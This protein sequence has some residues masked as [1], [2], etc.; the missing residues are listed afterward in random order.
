MEMYDCNVKYWG[1]GVK[2]SL[3]YI[4]TVRPACAACVTLSK[5]QKRKSG[6]DQAKETL[7]RPETLKHLFSRN[8]K[9]LLNQV[10]LRTPGARDWV[11][12][13]DY[14][15]ASL[16]ALWSLCAFCVR[17]PCAPTFTWGAVGS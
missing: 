16:G 14:P 15:T 9:Q 4:V 7:I 6:G 13:T 17:F 1:A 5:K 10:L 11:S 3:G 12:E 8:L 2:A